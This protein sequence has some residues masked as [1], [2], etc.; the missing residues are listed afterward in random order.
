MSN[1]AANIYDLINV[2]Q[3]QIDNIA[4]V[5]YPAAGLTLTRSASLALITAGTLITWQV[6]TRGYAITW[7]GTTIT[8]PSSGY[9]TFS[10]NYNSTVAH[11]ARAVLF[12][13]A[14]SVL[15]MTVDTVSNARHGATI[16]RYFTEDDAVQVMLLP[17]INTTMSVVA[18]G[19]TS[20]SPFLHVVQLTGSIE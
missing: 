9:Y 5:E 14:V 1:S 16:T 6:E 19:G 20:E 13:N 18:E 17:S 10:L 7:A 11:V 4:A 12:I 8:I 15:D 3:G 2:A